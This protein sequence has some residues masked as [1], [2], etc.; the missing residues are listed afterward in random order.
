MPSSR[1]VSVQIDAS[2]TCQ[3]ACPLCPTADGRLQPSL[4]AG[5]LSYNLYTT[6]GHSA[7][8]GDGSG[9]TTTVSDSYTLALIPQTRHY[10]VFGQIPASQNVSAGGYLDVVVVTVVY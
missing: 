8:W 2:L 3:L 7:V 5:H 9:S 4:G 1:P 6:A 10:T